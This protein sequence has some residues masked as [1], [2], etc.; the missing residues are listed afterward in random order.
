M[1]RKVERRLALTAEYAIKAV[2]GFVIR[3]ASG[4]AYAGEDLRIHARVGETP[5]R[6]A[7]GPAR[8]DR[9]AARAAAVHRHPAEI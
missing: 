9:A 7:V 8:Q 6:R 5:G 1:L 2:Y 3:K 4:A